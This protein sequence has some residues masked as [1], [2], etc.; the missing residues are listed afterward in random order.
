MA[1]TITSVNPV[2][3]KTTPINT[4]KK[5]PSNGKDDSGIIIAE[6]IIERLLPYN[7]RKSILVIPKAYVTGM[8][9]NMIN[10]SINKNNI[11]ATQAGKDVIIDVKEASIDKIKRFHPLF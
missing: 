3:S 9:K 2:F 4:N 10:A 6:I 1:S 7:I 8:P 5:T 11:A